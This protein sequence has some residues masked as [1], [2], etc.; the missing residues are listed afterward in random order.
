MQADLA[1]SAG[2]QTGQDGPSETS[3]AEVAAPATPGPT[4]IVERPPT[5][6]AQ[7]RYPVPAWVV[8]SVACLLVV[9]TV[10]YF[11]AR[12]RRHRRREE[13]RLGPSSIPPS[14]ARRGPAGR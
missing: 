10:G 14:S 12:H 13:E 7:G 5:T 4:V 8:V 2:P 6:L 11:V 3:S 9:G 1:P